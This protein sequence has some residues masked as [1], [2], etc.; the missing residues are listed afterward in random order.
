MAKQHHQVKAAQQ[1]NLKRFEQSY[2]FDDS[3]PDAGQIE[4]L[5]QLDTNILQWL[6]ERAEKEQQFRHS[7]ENDRMKL[8]D[9][10]ASKE[11]NTV[12]YGLTI[13]FILVLGAGF[14]SHLLLMAGH[15]LQGSLFG[16]TA[17]LL[18]LAVLV[19]KR[20]TANIK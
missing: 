14:A 11:Q 15:N 17:A 16:G 10:H 3:L 7:S 9:K 19:N 5:H 20:P 1:G 2:V 18:A 12:R 13:Y 4:R 8:T 6:K